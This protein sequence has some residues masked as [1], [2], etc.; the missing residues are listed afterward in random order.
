[1][2]GALRVLADRIQARAVRRMGELLKEFDGRGNNQHLA[3]NGRD[4][5]RPLV[6]ALE[7][8]PLADLCDYPDRERLWNDPTIGARYLRATA[9]GWIRRVVDKEAPF[10]PDQRL[11]SVLLT[12]DTVE[13]VL[14][15]LVVDVPTALRLIEAIPA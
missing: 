1:L 14:L 9:D 5:H 3:G 10:A 2:P 7:T 8:T 6:E 13:K 4:F 11:G 12:G 15:G